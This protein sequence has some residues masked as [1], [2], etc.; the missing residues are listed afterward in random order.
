MPSSYGTILIT[1]GSGFIG[2]NLVRRLAQSGARLRV[3]DNLSAGNPADIRPSGAELIVGDVR[4]GPLV[5]RALEGVE[6][7]IHLAAQTG[8]IPS[9]QNPAGDFEVNARATFELL[10]ASRNAGIRKF[11]FASTGGAI[12]GE[13]QPPIH[14]EMAARPL[15]PYGASKL[16]AEGYCSAFFGSFGLPA[17]SLRFSNIYGPHSYHKGSVIARFFKL[18]LEAR[19]LTVYGD[20]TQTRDFLYVQDLVEAILAALE[21]AP[22]GEVFHIASGQETSINE[23]IALLRQVVSDI[24]IK[25][26]YAPARRGEVSRNFASIDKARRLLSFHPR[27][28]LR[29]GLVKTWQWFSPRR[30]TAL[31]AGLGSQAPCLG[32]DSR[33]SV[34]SENG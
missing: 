17:V 3:L 29:D 5:R 22:G 1:G 2:T 32:Q 21:A 9:Q 14:E 4:D 13:K 30:G 10:A 33:P 28:T 16:A 6:A 24:P 11:I 20:G 26:E 19:P 18:L 15:S 23:L 8:V 12:L 27:V 34:C 25:V 7:V 31:S